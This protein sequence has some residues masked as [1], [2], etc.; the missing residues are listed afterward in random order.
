[1]HI[2]NLS[3]PPCELLDP[4]VAQPGVPVEVLAQERTIENGI[5][6]CRYLREMFWG[7]PRGVAHL[8][9]ERRGYVDDSLRTPDEMKI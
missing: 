2:V 6:V 7:A 9:S 8:L 4:E 3:R 1:M 5:G